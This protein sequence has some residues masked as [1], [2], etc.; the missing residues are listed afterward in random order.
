MGGCVQGA[1]APTSLEAIPSVAG[2]SEEER[3]ESSLLG[4]P[5]EKH[6]SGPSGWLRLPTLWI[7]DVLP[8]HTPRL[9]VAALSC[10]A[11][12]LACPSQG[13]CTGDS[14]TSLV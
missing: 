6:L 1:W 8:L 10:R 5:E 2:W 9:L 7:E 13:R 11:A 14:C 12:C 4:T 3:E